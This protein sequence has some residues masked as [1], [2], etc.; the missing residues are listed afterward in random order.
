MELLQNN[1]FLEKQNWNST[2]T[3]TQF[4]NAVN[5]ELSSFFNVSEAHISGNETEERQA[6]Y[7]V[8]TAAVVVLSLFYGA[9]CITAILGNFLVI[10]L[11]MVSLYSF[12]SF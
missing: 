3:N 6:L 1:S 5:S 4:D 11:V 12:I 9:I 8:P 10:C 2:N 7:E